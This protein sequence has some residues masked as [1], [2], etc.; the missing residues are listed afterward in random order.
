MKRLKYKLGNNQTIHYNEISN[1]LIKAI[2]YNNKISEFLNVFGYIHQSILTPYQI[3][4]KQLLGLMRFIT[5]DTVVSS[6]LFAFFKIIQEL[7]K[8]PESQI[9]KLPLISSINDSISYHTLG[10]I[11]FMSSELGK[12]TSIGGQGVMVNELSQGLVTLGEDVYVVTPYYHF[13]RRNQSDYLNDEQNFKYTL[14]F[15]IKL[16]GETHVIN[17]YEGKFN[18]VTIFFLHNVDMF[19]SANSQGDGM[20]T[21]KQI[22]VFAKAA[23]EVFCLKR[24]IPSL[25]VTNDWYTAL[26]PGYVKNK[27]FGDVFIGTKFVHLIHNLDVMYDGRI[28]LT[29]DQGVRYISKII[30]IFH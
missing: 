24:I 9:S 21:L 6:K 19:M 7:I 16:A 25:I 30:Y 11:A 28:H 1:I 15:E 26:V 12:W 5:E 18:G 3:E 8:K 14:D 17:L 23:L 29:H 27:A 22:C 20:L 4:L 10:P 2:K 13:N